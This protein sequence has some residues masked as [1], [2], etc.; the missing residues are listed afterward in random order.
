MRSSASNNSYTQISLPR[1]FFTLYVFLSSGLL[2]L[3]Q[4][5]LAKSLLPFVGGAPAAWITSMLFFQL[6]LLAGYGYAA[7]S[8]RLLAPRAQHWLHAALFALAALL[9]LPLALHPAAFDSAAAPQRWML[10]TLAL[11][12]GLPYFFLSANSSLLQHWYK[13]RFAQAPYFLFAASNAGSLIGLF[14]FPFVVE[15][16][17]DTPAQY[18]LWSMGF[19]LLGALLLALCLKSRAE[20][21]THLAPTRQLGLRTIALLV[22]LGFVPSSLML[23]STLYIAT[24]I[25]SFPLLWVV[26]LAL[27]LLSFIIAFSGQSVRWTRA[28]QQLHPLAVVA[29]IIATLI[30]GVTW[31]L[32]LHLLFFF[33]I[34]MS[35]HGRAATLKPDDA[36]IPWYYFWLSLGGVL[37]G[38][39]NSAA[40]YLFSDVYEYPLVLLLSVFLLPRLSTQPASAL[41]QKAWKPL[42]VIALLAVVCG[43]IWFA[44]GQQKSE[45]DT[46]TVLHK[47]RNFF[48]V[49]K[50]L[51]TSS[52]VLYQHGTTNHGFQPLDEA[53]RLHITSYYAPI[54]QLLATLPPSFFEQPF[55]VLGLGAGTMA[56]YAKA[57]QQI[58]FFEIDQAVIDIASNPAYFTYL[59]DCPASKQVIKGD[60]R[61]E[62]AKITDARYQ[63]LV[64]DAFTSDAVPF[65][66]LTKEA[67]ALYRTKIIPHTGMLVFNI[68]NRHFDYKPILA[69]I[70]SVNAMES[71][72][73]FHVDDK[74]DPYDVPSIWLIMLPQ[75]SPWK[76]ALEAAGFKPYRADT[77]PL[78][79]DH[80]SNILPMMKW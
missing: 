18:M 7:I 76:A 53:H 20:P 59:R 38:A 44:P 32:F 33:V 1:L 35:C 16:L 67:V 3:V 29:A 46:T 19:A 61:L 42:A 64:M 23:G 4:P 14:A 27:Y 13:L 26:P 70:A 12:V 37:G 77:Q 47:E 6:V 39:F 72:T 56:C 68:S 36:S 52:S 17:F 41:R 65:H 78:W 54:S 21:A 57:G 25:A 79:T 11:T 51:R 62:L 48:G 15:W 66:L 8:T 28:C 34:A 63:M 60:G 58:D 55:A 45:P 31:L 69:R 24:D 9:C 50:V 43:G 30:G 73:I 5:M 10:A 40:P 74:N 49:S 75:D 2:F 22:A 71:Y 80:Y